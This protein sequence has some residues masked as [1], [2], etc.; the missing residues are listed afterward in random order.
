MKVISK[1]KA[2]LV[3]D[4][5]GTLE[6]FIQ[7]EIKQT[8]RNAELKEYTFETT[9]TL[10]LNYGTENESY[11]VHKNRHGQEQIK[12]YTKSY[13]EYDA[14]KEL[15]LG[16]YPSDLKGSELDDYLLLCA[17][18]YNLKSDSIYGVE[19]VAKWNG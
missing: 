10:V 5:E 1:T 6:E 2:V 17:L 7:I 14:Q 4:R 9:D 11:Q 18:L 16:A 8:N 15:L 19:F 12:T 3:N 13:E